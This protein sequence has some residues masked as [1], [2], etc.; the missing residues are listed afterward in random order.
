MNQAS[1]LERVALRTMRLK[2]RLWGFGESIAA[3]GLLQAADRLEDARFSAFVEGLVR[4]WLLRSVRLNY[5]DHAAP[6]LE[7]LMLQDRRPDSEYLEAALRLGAMVNMFPMG[8]AGCRYHRPDL[9]G[10]NRQIWVDCLHVDPPFLAELGK[11]QQNASLLG[12]AEAMLKSYA[13]LLQDESSGLFWHGYEEFAG[14]NGQAWARGNAWALLG[15]AESIPTLKSAGSDTTKLEQILTNLAAGLR[16]TQ[17]GSGLWHTIVTDPDT[18]EESTL[19]AAVA[20]GFEHCFRRGLLM[21]TEFGDC[22][23]RARAAVLPRINAEGE[24]GL[25]SDATPIGDRRNYATRP[26]GVFAWGQGLALQMLAQKEGQ[27]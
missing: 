10:W 1:L 3:R 15:L 2:F 4:A 27:Q 11:R 22:A 6:G 16:Q 20:H 17:C 14:R 7:L 8:A 23:S 21:R 26:F 19:A 9:S 18:Y 25:V 24:L 13:R 5:E 12:E